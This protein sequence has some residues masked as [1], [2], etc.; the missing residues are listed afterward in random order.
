MISDQ[1]VFVID[2][3]E[4]VRESIAA[5]I[6]IR[7]NRVRKFANAEEFLKEFQKG[8]PGCVVTDLRIETGMS[9]IELQQA[10]KERGA[11]IPVIVISAY[12]NVRNAV[13]AM[14][15]GA[16][17]LLEKSCSSDELWEAIQSALQRDRESRERH[18]VLQQN[19][20]RFARL[21]REEL[22]VMVRVVRG[23]LNKAVAREL[24]ISLRTVETRRHNVLQ[25]L[26]VDSVPEL[27]RLYVELEQELGRPVEEVL[28]ER[29]T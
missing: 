28:L 7:G 20:Q 10:L 18:N 15:Q 4:A 14:H 9:G 1:T 21:N 22:E 2:D 12:A 23:M 17:T 11:E 3:D 19:L 29:L 5:L 13:Q 25:K 16:V 24:T 26:E 27:V 8:T 6:E